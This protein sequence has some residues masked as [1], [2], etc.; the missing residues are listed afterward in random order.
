MVELLV[1]NNA[2]VNARNNHDQTA[3]D[4]IE[5]KGEVQKKEYLSNKLL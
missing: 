2:D 1:E 5:E 4:L 3:C